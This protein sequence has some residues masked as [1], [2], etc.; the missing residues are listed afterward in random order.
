LNLT[1]EKLIYGG[2]GL[3]RLP[4]ECGADTP[5]R[6]SQSKGKAVF[7]PFTLEGET[8]AATLTEQKPGFARA[9][10]DEVLSPSPNRIAPLCPYFQ[11]CGGCHY[12]HTSYEHQLATKSSILRE[13]LRRQ[14]KVELVN[15]I[16]VHPSEPWH[17]RNRTRFQ[18]RTSPEFL[19]GYFRFASHEVLAVEDCPI[20][21]LLINRA[22]KALWRLGRSAEVP[23]ELR[24]IEFF[25]N[26][27]DTRLL[28]EL[29]FTAETPAEKRI[30]LGEKFTN[31]LRDELPDLISAYVFAQMPTRG[32][33]ALAESAPDWALGGGQFRYLSGATEF[34]VSGGSFFQV[35]RFMLGKLV[36][37]VTAGVQ[38][39]EKKDLALDLYAGVGLFTT[40]LAPFFRHIVS[41][42][43]S[44]SSS[45]DLKYNCPANGKIVRATVEEYLAGQPVQAA[46]QRSTGA[47][48]KGE[49][50]KLKKGLQEGQIR[51]DTVWQGG[52]Q[53]ANPR[54]FPSPLQAAD[55]VVVDPP[56]AGLGDR[57]A[58]ALAKS[59][60]S[61][62]TYVSCDPATLARDLV[63]LT[64]GGY[65]VEQVHL[66][67]LFPQT[68][69]LESVVHL[70][71]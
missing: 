56:R 3:A 52:M 7:V 38:K 43:S 37:L 55:L 13:T 69:H 2:D 15:D 27:D 28:A 44:Q 25:A 71:R 58:Q 60:A 10:L 8:I 35:N 36:E 41:V 45:A 6:G 57:V 33:Q 62:I 23:A 47:K 68:F 70:V 9:Q 67:D 26:A 4:A 32:P 12:Q 63:H 1:I 54:A 14:G 42:E 18:V 5:V 64:A 22:L 21:S 17:Y 46:E 53:A 24:E 19:A 39:L 61:R 11:R 50:R 34:R 20:S 29:W 66:V 49:R 51:H 59:R 48:N 40:A 30:A 31:R 65:R 16:V